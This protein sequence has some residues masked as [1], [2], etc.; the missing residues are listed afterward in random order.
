MISLEFHHIG[1]ACRDLNFEVQQLEKLGYEVEG[2]A[3]IDPVQGV[4][5]V[6]LTGPGPRLEV[7][8]PLEKEGV[9]DPWLKTGTKLYHLAYYSSG[10]IRSQIST[11]KDL[12]AKVVVHP[13][14]SVAFGGAEISF[15]IF[16][17]MLMI[18]IIAYEHKPKH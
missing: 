1:V 11:F 6:F 10:D 2:S 4:E 14:A 3:F 9:L 12:G 16:P 15:L 17:N 7:L 8:R 13:V 18:E 5:G